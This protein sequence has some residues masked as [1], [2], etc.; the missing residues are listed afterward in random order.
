MGLM[1]RGLIREG[2]K[3]DITVFDFD[4]IKDTA[5]WDNPTAK[6]TGIDYVLV[7][8]ALVLDAGSHTGATP[9]QV[10]RG[11]A[12]KQPNAEDKD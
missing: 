7:N 10:L 6:P 4:E 1:D 8:G 9:G 2:L 11:P 3:A 12:Y 5:D